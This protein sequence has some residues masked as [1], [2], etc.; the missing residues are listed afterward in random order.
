MQS[1][2]LFC[3][4]QIC[5]SF[6]NWTLLSNMVSPMHLWNLFPHPVETIHV[7]LL[8]NFCIFPMR[9]HQWVTTHSN[10]ISMISYSMHQKFSNTMSCW[11]SLW[12]IFMY[13]KYIYLYI[14]YNG[15]PN[16]FTSTILIYILIQQKAFCIESALNQAMKNSTYISHFGKH[17][18]P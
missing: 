17:R 18:L 5:K 14:R 13:I 11:N 12:Y 4:F 6:K 16:T 15:F 8:Y 1:A 10:W 2:S 3:L 7:N 9:S